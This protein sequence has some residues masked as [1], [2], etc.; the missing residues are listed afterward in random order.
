MHRFLIAL[1]FLSCG[2]PAAAQSPDNLGVPSHTIDLQRADLRERKQQI[3][4]EVMRLD[5][6][7]AAAFWPVY[8]E[9]AA[10]Q[11]GLGD[12]RL[13][14]MKLL[15]HK[16][17]SLSEDEAKQLVERSIGIEKERLALKERY[18]KKMCKI[19]PARKVARFFQ[20]EN[21]LNLALELQVYASLP[22]I[23]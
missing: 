16:Y 12:R 7:E 3:I 23:D 22:V 6:R 10:E 18:F 11:A 5:E 2:L 17:D 19:L 4:A 20:V 14:N 1:A 9:Y 8:Q 21:Q 13:E 15:L